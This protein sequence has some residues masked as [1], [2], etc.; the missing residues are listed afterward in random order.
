MRRELRTRHLKVHRD[1]AE[2]KRQRL[3]ALGYRTA[4]F[5]VSRRIYDSAKVRAAAAGH[6]MDLFCRTALELGLRT[7][8]PSELSLAERQWREI[9]PV[10]KYDGFRSLRSKAIEMRNRLFAQRKAK[11]GAVFLYR[12]KRRRKA[13]S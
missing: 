4:T 6:T 13:A 3:N 1:L 10:R 7:L 12:K 9:Y 8:R 11:Y 5:W 2:K